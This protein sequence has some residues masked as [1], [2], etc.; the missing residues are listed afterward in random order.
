[1]SSRHRRAAL[2]GW[3]FEADPSARGRRG[4]EGLQ[5]RFLR[6]VD[7]P[8]SLP[9]PERQRRAERLR[10]AHFILLAERSAEVRRTRKQVGGDET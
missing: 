10:K 5:A 6:E 9:E 1:V 4:Q 8:G 7:P 3:A 2:I